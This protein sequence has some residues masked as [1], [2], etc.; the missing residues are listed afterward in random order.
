ML[1]DF[2]HQLDIHWFIDRMHF[3]CIKNLRQ[4]YK[5][6]EQGELNEVSER[7]LLRNDEGK[8]EWVHL[9]I[10]RSISS[11]LGHESFICITNITEQYDCQKALKLKTKQLELVQRIGKLGYFSYDL[12]KQLLRF[13]RETLELLNFDPNIPEMS[14][15]TFLNKFPPLQR[16]ILC[17]VFYLNNESEEDSSELL[18]HFSLEIN[19]EIKSFKIDLDLVENKTQTGLLGLIV[20]VTR[21]VNSKDFYKRVSDDFVNIM[22]T[23][24]VGV[25]MFTKDGNV[26]YA[27]DKA[28]NMVSDITYFDTIS[29][30]SNVVGTNNTLV[31]NFHSVLNGKGTVRK[32]FEIL[33]LAEGKTTVID[34]TMSPAT[35][36]SRNEDVVILTIR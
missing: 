34:Y 36:N 5:Q 35:I 12:R 19:G 27:N 1:F 11:V 23:M 15:K 13:N 16:D 2:I 21:E 25:L 32:D 24:P 14:F 22:D 10:F 8:Y 28:N 7:C 26:M 29:S 31:D 33:T 9:S 17:N 30:W 4:K 18:A 20:D 6:Y 3:T